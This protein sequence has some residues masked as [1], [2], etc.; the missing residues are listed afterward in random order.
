MEKCFD[1]K[2]NEITSIALGADGVVYGLDND[3]NPT[4]TIS[5]ECCENLG[6]SF[7]PDDALCYW[8]D[9]KSNSSVNVIINSDG[10][11]GG[12]FTLPE[13]SSCKFTLGLDYLFV[14]KC[15]KKCEL[16]FEDLSKL[17]INLLLQTIDLDG[18]IENFDLINL[19]DLTNTSSLN[20]DNTGI[21]FEKKSKY[22][23]YLFNN[24]Q[25]GFL[26]NGYDLTTNSFNST[27]VTFNKIYEVLDTIQLNNKKIRLGFNIENLPCGLSIRVDNIKLNTNCTEKVKTSSYIVKNPSFSFERMVDNKK[28]WLNDDIKREHDLKYRETNYSANN[29]SLILNS[30]EIDL[31]FSSNNGIEHDLW[32]FVKANPELIND[33]SVDGV[34]INKLIGNDWV[35]LNN[36]RDFTNLL[37][38]NLIDVKNHKTLSDYPTLKLLYH[39]YVNSFL[40]VGVQSNAFTYNDMIKYIDILDNYWL[41]LIEQFIPSTS[42]WESTIKLSNSIFDNQKFVYKK[43]NLHKIDTN[44]CKENTCADSIV[45]NGSLNENLIGWDFPADTWYVNNGMARYN[46]TIIYQS[47][48]IPITQNILTIGKKYKI[49]LTVDLSTSDLS[50][51]GLVHFVKVY[52]GNNFRQLDSSGTYEFELTADDTLFA[53]EAND[54]DNPC[55]LGSYGCKHGPIG[56]S[57]VCV[58]ELICDEINS[59]SQ[60]IN[61]DILF[62][63]N[64]EVHEVNLNNPSESTNYNGLAIYQINDGSE[65]YSSIN[66]IT[67]GENKISGGVIMLTESKDSFSQNI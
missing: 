5:A 37:I 62:S 30:K 39:R 55:G 64:I 15:E 42:I 25:D 58:Y 49:S 51:G 54:S 13:E 35:K 67:P 66:I 27:W 11:T 33:I 2:G 28:T 57:N 48:T 22:C 53:I 9:V 61:N 7:D 4:Y 14:F 59:N 45:Q 26:N 16:T 56:I 19:I 41:D 29:E 17:K 44:L 1:I 3:D 31:H 50:G 36:L 38:T 65:F 21:L 40:Y 32:I 18:N 8:S 34:D 20:N 24:I 6:Y 12:Y 46:G 52:A 63:H 23:S 47:P 10:N 60:S 43:Y